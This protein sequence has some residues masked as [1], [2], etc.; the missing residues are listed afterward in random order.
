MIGLDAI[1]LLGDP[2]LRQV[3]EPVVPAEIAALQPWF[4]RMH[5]L[6][7]LFRKTYGRG[8]AIAAPQ[9]GLLKRVVCLYIDEPQ[10]LINPT[11]SQRSEE[12]F[13]LWDDCMSFP[14][15]MVRLK[16]HHSVQLHFL[17]QYGQSQTWNLEGDLS[18]LL[19]H[20]LDH[21]DGILALDYARNA[22]DLKWVV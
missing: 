16:R 19:Q 14:N 22:D 17:D 3:C 6:I 2:R 13:E 20:E 8:R 21:L 10:V 9:V 11:F 5:Q 7:L 15:L 4:D 12:M 18:E 1:L